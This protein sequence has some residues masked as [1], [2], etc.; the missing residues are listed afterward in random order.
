MAEPA[1]RLATWEDLWSLPEGQ[2]AEIVGGQIALLPSPSSHHQILIGNL[3]SELAPP[4]M[5][6]RGGGPGGW[7]I[8]AD[9]D[10]ALG[11]HD[12]VRPDLAGWRWE[13]HPTC[14]QRPVTARPDWVCE[15]LSPS[16]ARRDRQQ[17]MELY[18]R[19]GVEFVWLIDPGLRLLEAY[20]LT[21]DLYTRLGAWSEETAAIP[22]FEAVELDVADLFAILG[23][24]PTPQELDRG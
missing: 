11:H 6:R 12:V 2:R 16:N 14:P 18:R 10:V 15:V 8:I 24:E 21:G 5:R 22:P 1:L 3:N 20:R 4:F 19:A 7:W 17:K 23:P 13:R 9:V